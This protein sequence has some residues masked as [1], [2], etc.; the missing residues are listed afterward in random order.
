MEGCSGVTGIVYNFNNKNLVTFEDNFSATGDLPMAIYF[1]Y[2]TAAP[3]DNYFDPQQKKIFVVSYVLIV[4]F[5]PHLNIRTIVVQRSYSHSLK[6]LTTIDYLSEDQMK[7]I[8]VKLVKQ[9]NDVAQEV[10][11]KKKKKM[12]KCSRTNVFY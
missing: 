9:L 2:E 1:N 5:H 3:T 8:D 11:K 7:H 4:A 12:Q 10:S 6:Q